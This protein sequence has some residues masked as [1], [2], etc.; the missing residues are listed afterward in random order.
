MKETEE[1]DQAEG[2]EPESDGHF[3][4]G[5]CLA[6]SYEVIIFLSAPHKL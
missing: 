6:N 2:N 1:G 5:K 4:Q 3:H